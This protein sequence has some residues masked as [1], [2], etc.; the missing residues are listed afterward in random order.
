MKPTIGRIVRYKLTDQ[1][2]NEIVHHEGEDGTVNHLDAGEE[3]AAV[4]VR[5]F[6]DYPA[7]E[8]GTRDACNLRLLI[9]GSTRLPWVTSRHEGTEPGTWHWPERS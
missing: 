8:G 7:P 9:D 6:H 2:V 1:D 5:V 4:V 3:V